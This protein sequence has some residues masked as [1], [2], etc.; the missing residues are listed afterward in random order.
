VDTQTYQRIKTRRASYVAQRDKIAADPTLSVLGRRRAGAR[1]YQAAKGDI[2]TLRKAAAD[3]YTSEATRHERVLFGI[4]TSNPTAVIAH[5]DAQDRAARIKTPAEAVELLRRAERAQDESLAQAVM[6]V[7]W[8]RA[9]DVAPGWVPIVEA[10]L[11][12]R[13]AAKAASDALCA[14]PTSGGA[15]ADLAEQML[16]ALPL[17]AGFT[18]AMTIQAAASEAADTDAELSDRGKADVDLI[19]TFHQAGRYPVDQAGR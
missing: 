1:A 6:E 13:P 16:T 4:A 7:A 2:A 11:E 10:Y 12:L 19:R 15:G 8:Q 9:S 18:D 14:L 3:H 5:R 17:P